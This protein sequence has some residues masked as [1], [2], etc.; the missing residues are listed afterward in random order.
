[1][2]RAGLGWGDNVLAK[3]GQEAGVETCETFFACHAREAGHEP[4][5][6][7][8][9]GHK[10]YACCLKRSKED[11]REEPAHTVSGLA[12]GQTTLA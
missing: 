12:R 9:L 11:I 3:N 2:E 8:P 5:G 10:P 4:C 7:P 1:M 6:V